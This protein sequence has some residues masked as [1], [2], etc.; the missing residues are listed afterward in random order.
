[1]LHSLYVRGRRNMISERRKIGAWWYERRDDQ[2]TVDPVLSLIEDAR[3]VLFKSKGP[4]GKPFAKTDR[5]L[6]RL[7]D[8]LT[9]SMR[10]LRSLL[11]VARKLTTSWEILLW[12]TSSEAPKALQASECSEL[13]DSMRASCWISAQHW[14]DK[15]S[16][17]FHSELFVIVKFQN[18]LLLLHPGYF[19]FFWNLSVL[20]HF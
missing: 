16:S 5:D 13:L 8:K 14:P 15:L 11:A 6:S 3:Q 19:A 20:F 2:D 7:V 12:M 17:F 4:R 18:V 9:S 10:T 1:M